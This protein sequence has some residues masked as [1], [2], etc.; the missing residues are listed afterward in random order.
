M[1]LMRELPIL[2]PVRLWPMTVVMCAGAIVIGNAVHAEETKPMTAFDAE[3]FT[4]P[5]AE[6]RP[7]QIGHEFA[8]GGRN[9]EELSAEERIDRYLEFMQRLGIGGIVANVGYEDYLQSPEQWEIWRYGAAKT[10]ARGMTLW[11]YDERAYPSGTAGGIVTRA[12]PE[13]T[14]VG[15][16]CYT[17]SAKGGEAVTIDLPVSAKVC[18]GVVA[19]AAETAQAGD[20]MVDLRDQVDDWGTLRWTPPKGE[21]TVCYFAQRNIFE[22]TFATT[23]PHGTTR[24]YIDVLNPDAVKAFIRVTHQAYLRHTPPEVWKHIQAVFTDEPL[25]NA[26]YVGTLPSERE[27]EQFVLDEPYFLDRPPSVTWTLSFVEKFEALK[28]YDIRPHLRSLFTGASPH[29]RYVRQDYW[30]VATRLY[31]QAYHQQIAD[32]CAANGIASSGHVLAEEG[33]YGNIMFQGSLMA[34]IRPMQL[35]GIDLLS[36]DPDEVLTKHLMAPKAVSS[37]AHLT[38]CEMVQCETSGHNQRQQGS[39]VGLPEW[40]GQANILYAMGVNHLT[41]YHNWTRVGEDGYRA[42]NDYVGRLGV[43]LRGGSHV[44]DVA[45]LYPVRT[46]WSW[47]TPWG[48]ERASTLPRESLNKGMDRIA[49]RYHEAGLA[50]A[51]SQIDFDLVDE[52]AVQ[53]ATMS[54]AAMRVADEGY[55]VIVLPGVEALELKTAQ[56][57]ER[58][59]AAGGIVLRVW[60]T[61]ELADSEQNQA[62]FGATMKRLFGTAGAPLNV[63][64]LTGEIKSRIGADFELAEPDEQVCYLHRCKEGRD[65]YFIVNNHAEAITLVPRLRAQG[66]WKVYRPLTGGIEDAPADLRL[67]LEGYEGVF[68]VSDL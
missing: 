40:L 31:T 1:R 30:D 29:D 2:S 58:F 62:E 12:H 6:F 15:L 11:F 65:V 52:Q 50:L 56:A 4:N 8:R 57:L 5:P 3:M 44:C 28:S 7:M 54:N 17:Y 26:P 33:L 35:P 41:L 32:W 53:E 66:P 60:E 14:A 34:V 42:Y 13:Y 64:Q 63:K 45:M 37:V 19:Y 39:S 20:T 49:H 61:P 10:V 51:Q 38:G 9:R 48:G 67:P 23:V 24:M 25:L 27:G 47:W 21:W 22:G 46:G 18:V 55:R 59:A 16:A 36:A 43:M 68:L